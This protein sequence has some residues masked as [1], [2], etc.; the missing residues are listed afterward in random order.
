MDELYA[1]L[2][3]GTRMAPL[4]AR[5]IMGMLESGSTVPL[6]DVEGHMLPSK[7]DPVVITGNEGATVQLAACCLP[8]PGDKLTGHLKHD[9]ALIIHT[10]DC[11]TAKRYREKEPDRWIEVIWGDEL[12]RRFE[13]RITILTHNQKGVLARIAAEINESDAHIVSVT[14]ND[15]GDASMK[16]LRFTIQVEDRVHLA[17][18]MRGIRNIDGVTRILR[19]RS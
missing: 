1:D 17:R 19:E 15:D 16:H 6:L 5:H 14:M 11:D 2:G 8:I 10:E 12:N 4:V 18:T 9:Q 7:P 13:S 3:I